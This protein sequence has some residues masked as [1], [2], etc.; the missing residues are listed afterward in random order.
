MFGTRLVM[1]GTRLVMFGTR[2]VMFWTRLVMF[3]TRLVM[4]VTSVWILDN[5]NIGSSYCLLTL[6]NCCFTVKLLYKASLKTMLQQ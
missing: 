3:G 2:L 5:Q 1:F 6:R 4:F